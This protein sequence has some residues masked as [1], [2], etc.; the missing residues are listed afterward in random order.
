MTHLEA[1]IVLRDKVK[2]GTWQHTDWPTVEKAFWGNWNEAAAYFQSAYSG[3]LDAAKALH[4]AVLPGWGWH[5]RQDEKDGSCHAHTL[6][7]NYRVSPGGH[8]TESNPARA[9]LL[10]I[11]EALI[12]QETDK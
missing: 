8:T 6:Y 11:L 4:E 12:A 2:A 1:L 5:I 9:W 10:A 7:P 3:S